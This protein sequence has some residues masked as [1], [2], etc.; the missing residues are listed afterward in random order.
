M[1]FYA[2]WKLLYGVIQFLHDRHL[3]WNCYSKSLILNSCTLSIFPALEIKKLVLL[4]K[5]L[6]R[7]NI[8]FHIWLI[9]LCFS[10]DIPV[11][12][13]ILY[14]MIKILHEEMLNAIYLYWFHNDTLAK[15]NSL[16]GHSN[17]PWINGQRFVIF[18]VK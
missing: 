2:H 16:N 10:L 4:G 12:I 13:T 1:K 17:Q 14:E 7:F 8:I 15:N 11:M 6:W 5:M 9:N 3:Q 18:P